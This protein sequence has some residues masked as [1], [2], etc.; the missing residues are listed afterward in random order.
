MSQIRRG[1]FWFRGHSRQKWSL[2][3]TIYRGKKK[4]ESNLLKRFKQ[5]ATLLVDPRPTKPIEW[6]FMMR[7]YNVPTRLLDWTESPLVA[8]TL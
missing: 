3:P 4:I 2:I 5:D 6:L 7:H 1:P 8:L